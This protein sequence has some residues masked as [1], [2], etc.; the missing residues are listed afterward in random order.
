MKA[1]KKSLKELI[2]GD[3]VPVKTMTGKTIGTV[4][5]ILWCMND[6]WISAHVEVNGKHDGALQGKP[7]T[8]TNVLVSLTKEK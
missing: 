2:I 4:S 8:L 7:D 1:I 6:T 3:N 5:R